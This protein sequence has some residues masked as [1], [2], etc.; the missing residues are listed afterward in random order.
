L[1]AVTTDGYVRFWLFFTF[2][3][4]MSQAIFL[5]GIV[6]VSCCFPGF[7]NSSP[8]WSLVPQED[9]PKLPSERHISSTPDLSLACALCRFWPV[10]P[11]ALARFQP[12][13]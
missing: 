8:N 4:V 3:M 10:V 12:F 6:T 11:F 1:R 2:A 5:A 9:I 13:F 7:A